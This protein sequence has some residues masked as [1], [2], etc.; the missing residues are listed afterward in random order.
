M[1]N[2]KTLEGIGYEGNVKI[3][4][5]AGKKTLLSKTIHNNG[6]TNL[7]RFLANCLKGD[8]RSD[9]LPCRIRLFNRSY[10]NN[11][12]DPAK[13]DTW[14]FNEDYGICPYIYIATSAVTY[15]TSKGTAQTKYVFRIPYSQITETE[16]YKL[17]LYSKKTSNSDTDKYAYIGLTDYDDET[18]QYIWKPLI[19]STDSKKYALEIEWTLEVKNQDTLTTNNTTEN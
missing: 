3:C 11:E 8:F 4:I 2:I 17:A 7:F 6:T 16:I 12:D 13:A 19:L 14:K 1:D 15:D 9:M 18:K 5:K 10:T